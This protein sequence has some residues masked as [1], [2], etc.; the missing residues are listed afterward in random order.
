MAFE[1]GNVK[2]SGSSPAGC[3]RLHAA[4]CG[5]I[6]PL[7]GIFVEFLAELTESSYEI[8]HVLLHDKL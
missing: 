6:R 4:S 5:C 3:L 7:R 8:I 2:K 1:E